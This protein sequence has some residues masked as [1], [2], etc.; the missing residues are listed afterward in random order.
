MT[1]LVAV[2]TVAVVVCAS[3]F[4]AAIEAGG[5]G[6]AAVG[7]TSSAGQ[8]HGAVHDEQGSPVTG[9]VV[10]VV[11]AASAFAV[12]D[13]EGRFLF[14][15]LP[16]GT[17]LLRAHQQ[18]FLPVRAV[19]VQVNPAAL[20]TRGLRLSRPGAPRVLTAGAGSEAGVSP[21]QPPAADPEPAESGSRTE[22]AW[23][24]RHLKR[25]VLEESSIAGVPARE[26]V[27]AH[28]SERSW[29][30]GGSAPARVAAALADIPF[31]GQLNLLTGTTFDRPQRMLTRGPGAPH[32]VAYASLL[33]PSPIG[34]WHLRGA[35][36]QGDLSSWTL[37]GAFVREAP[38]AHAYEAGAAYTTQRYDGGNAAALAAM[39]DGSRN[40]GAMY[41]YDHW[42]VHP[43]VSID[44]G[45]RYAWY[46]F[47]DGPGLLSP[48]AG[49]TVDGLGIS[50]RGAVSS[51]ATAPGAA[52][53]EAPSG[54]EMWLPPERTFASLNRDGAFRRERTTHTEVSAQRAL[55]GGLA[56]AARAFRQHVDDQLAA[57]F[58]LA[59]A[60]APT[61][62]VGHY[63]QAAVGGVTT[64]G[65]GVGVS[66]SLTGRVRGSI[67]YTE[68]RATWDR[69]EGELAALAALAPAA[70]RAER[71]RLRDIAATV[72]AD[73][74]LT[75]TRVFVFYRVNTAHVPDGEGAA[76]PPAT[77][78][79]VQVRQAL[80]FLSFTNADWAM[81]VTVRNVFTQ[82][83]ADAS[84]YDE[85]LVIRPPKRIVGGLTV[86]F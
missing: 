80:P 58:S 21:A 77:R 53:F 14:M 15:A 76:L 35:L 3:G 22:L 61:S 56:L 7:R 8:L 10:S 67:E 30:R 23:R 47:M 41:A 42:K 5:P 27:A 74:P 11:G 66:R 33:A 62:D 17:Y 82:G 16:P 45:A 24:L 38:A 43:R 79:D 32:G 52:E 20:T 19:L 71:E 69:V 51:R 46:D 18:G 60:H 83:A 28:E 37:A 81:L 9:A 78:F 36:T 40:A 29:L 55:P 57:M 75:T 86:R 34:Q 50:L 39:P 25:G 72:E 73:V 31:S 63:Y 84:V 59:L 48:T 12:T 6:G 2:V 64:S 54:T 1:R 65:W 85:L 68:S 44:Y 4:S 49:V 70:V 26:A 13:G